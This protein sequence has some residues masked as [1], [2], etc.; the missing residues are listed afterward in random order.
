M[1]TAHPPAAT[2]DPTHA[3]DSP[4]SARARNAIDSPSSVSAAS[5]P[6]CAEMDILLINPPWI[7][8]DQNIWH[9][10]KGAM[11]PLGLL[12]IAAYAE[13]EGF[14]VRI[15]DLH[16]ERW[17]IEEFRTW[18]RTVLPRC[19]GLTMMTATS[20]AANRVAVV[21]KE[22]HP[23]CLV[24]A[25]G[26]H[27]EAMPTECLKNPAIDLV[28]RGDGEIT[29]TRILR[30]EPWETI[31][32]LSFRRPQPGG[33]FLAVHNPPAEVIE[34]LDTLPMPAYHLVPM[35]RYF[36]SLGAYK[37]LPAINMLMTRGCPGKCTF[38][39]S[40]E[41]KLRTR[42][43]ARVVE[44]I[45]HLRRTYGIREIQFY[46]DTFTVFKQNVSAFCR[47]M[48]EKKLGVSWT[49]FVRTDCF[50]E[51]LA[52]EMKEAGCHQ[53]M[54]G[55]E[56]GDDE[57][58]RNIR[59]PIDRRKTEWAVKVA[60][61]LGL[62]VRATFML[63]NPGETVD[64]MR[65]TIDYAVELDPDLAIFN[66]TTPYPGTQMFEW[67][68][69]NGLLLT[70]DWGDYELSGAIMR[71]PTVSYEEVA[72]WYK[73]AYAAF[74][75]RPIM[76]WRRAMKTRNIHHLL[77]HVH[78]FF[79]IILRRNLGRRAYARREWIASVKEDF[80]KADV[81]DPVFGDRLIRTNEIHKLQLGAPP[82]LGT[83]SREP[84]FVEAG[85]F[86]LPV[87]AGAAAS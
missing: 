38:C 23:D 45:E 26:V 9:G 44:E 51:D 69:R 28:V 73:K 61:R 24:I 71:L 17:G 79:Y 63:G 48:R 13:R 39:N 78:A 31:K 81:T 25:G 54:F 21:V 58:L 74:Y 10:I 67:A 49:A 62:E 70:E 85:A 22:V 11:P 47:L 27:A 6:A 14:N 40:A 68:K 4:S 59:K 64:T 83:H 86:A 37:R 66:I 55:V 80:W 2:P 32:G 30:G 50:A 19:V 12:S 43:A 52:R 3:L 56:S 76:F 1:R 18:L 53:V 82:S 8:K 46:D 16:V 65:R 84:D 36:P 41:T 57:I 7:S 60:K 33:G 29:L 35:H 15:L 87:L 34:D 75:N 77:D 42:S 72:E 20:I 5:P